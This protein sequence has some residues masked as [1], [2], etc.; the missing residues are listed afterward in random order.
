MDFNVT[1]QIERLHDNT[2]RFQEK[3]SEIVN[4]YVYMCEIKQNSD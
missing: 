4:S 2:S 1:L 3:N